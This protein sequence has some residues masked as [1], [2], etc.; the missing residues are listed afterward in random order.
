[1]EDFL[2]KL[3][4]SGNKGMIYFYLGAAAVIA[5]QL[6]LLVSVLPRYFSSLKE[7]MV[8]VEA[9]QIEVSS[10]GKALK[11]LSSLDASQVDGYLNKVLLALPDEKK[12]SGIIS[13]MTA[14][15]SSSGVVV[16]GLEFSPGFVATNSGQT[17]ETPGPEEIV[18]AGLNLRAIPAS[19]TV[20]A[21][22]DSLINF[23]KKLSDASQ[24]I[25]VMG[26]NYGSS[27]P[28]QVKA[29]ILIKIY[30]QPRDINKFAWKDLKPI[31]DEDISFVQALPD[32]DLFVLEAPQGRQ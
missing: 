18:E 23:L 22:V 27:G 19:L 14:L 28:D 3:T 32:E 20:T 8:T 17:A 26:V 7:K 21:S 6:I 25:G 31:Q 2:K 24:L 16:T 30:Y 11:M 10:Y 29:T 5:L 9:R 4:G 1:M 13:G 15:A 12:T